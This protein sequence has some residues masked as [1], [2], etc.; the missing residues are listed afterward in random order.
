MHKW[1]CSSQHLHQPGHPRVMTWLATE[2]R[3]TT[4]GPAMA[5]DFLHRLLVSVSAA[6][7]LQ[8]CFPS[9]SSPLCRWRTGFASIWLRSFGTT[10]DDVGN[11]T[12]SPVDGSRTSLAPCKAGRQRDLGVLANWISVRLGKSHIALSVYRWEL[13]ENW[14]SFPCHRLLRASVGYR[15]NNVDATKHGLVS[16]VVSTSSLHSKHRRTRIA[17]AAFC[18][19]FQVS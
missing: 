18:L 10:S 3:S 6:V 7:S 13:L 16:F 1:K 19:R 4:R 2:P 5:G 17:H 8:E 15:G 9:A 12:R 11:C 14:R